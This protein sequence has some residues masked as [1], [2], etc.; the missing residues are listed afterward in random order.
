MST[1]QTAPA[2]ESHVTMFF[3]SF[4]LNLAVIV[5]LIVAL[6]FDYV[7]KFFSYWYIRHIPYKYPLPGFGSDYHRVLGLRNTTDEV[8]KL[9]Q[10][11][12]KD[13]LVGYIKS[14]IPDLMV[15]D[16]EIIKLLLSKESENFNKR[17]LCLERSLD[18]C[19]RN[20][21]FYAEGEKWDL[22]RRNFKSIL[23]SRLR[24]FE[25]SERSADKYL[26][27]VN[28]EINVQNFLEN[29]MDRVITDLVFGEHLNDGAETF[30][31]NLRCELRNLTIAGRFKS[32]LKSL[33]PSIY[34]L[35]GL[36]T[37]KSQPDKSVHEVLQKSDLI[38]EVRKMNFDSAVDNLILKLGNHR[39][40]NTDIVFSVLS[41][42]ITEGYTPCLNILACL[43]YELSKDQQMQDAVRQQPEKF[44]DIAIKET[45]R[46]YPP[47]TVISR[48]C[49]KM[50]KFDD[51]NLVIHRGVTITVPIASIHK[52]ETYFENP[53]LF[54]PK[55]FSEEIANKRPEC[56]YLPYGV[57]PKKCIGQEL[58][59]V[60]IR[61]ITGAIL[62]KYEIEPSGKTPKKLIFKDHDFQRVLDTKLYLNFNPIQ[63]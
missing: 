32:Y 33:F 45:M 9:Y 23:Q 60:I 39:N 7:T 16:P 38:H 51:S 3:E 43:L 24:K 29:I 53:E 13:K 11:H 37:L 40:S 48:Q 63:L 4:L 34:I 30:V 15:K 27:D 47:Y 8:D 36:I 56:S 1:V 35:L 5:V 26:R 17:G 28:G 44:L 18:G 25:Q 52:D 42:F 49:T 59:Q 14:R 21:L 31:S 46:L 57:G 54:D 10:K 12:R 20:N 2:T 55:R 61:S 41:L 50:Y 6:V 58:S 19:L 62:R 22:L